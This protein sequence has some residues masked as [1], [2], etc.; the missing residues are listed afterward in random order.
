MRFSRRNMILW[1]V[2]Q[3]RGKPV[4]Q[5]FFQPFIR[6]MVQLKETGVVWKHHGQ[7]ICSRAILLL[8]TVDLQAKAYLTEMTMF[9]GRHGCITCEDEGINLI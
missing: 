2:W 6:H 9:N 1:G 5:T 3:A 8:G 4:F 7:E